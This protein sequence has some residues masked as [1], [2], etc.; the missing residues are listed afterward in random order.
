MKNSAHSFKRASIAAK[1]TPA[2]RAAPRGAG[3]YTSPLTSSIFS[4]GFC[5]ISILLIFSGLRL[6]PAAIRRRGVAYFATAQ[7]G[8]GAS[9]I[10]LPLNTA[11]RRL[12]AH[13]VARIRLLRSLCAHCV[14][15]IRLRRLASI[16][17]KLIARK[18][19]GFRCVVSQISFGHEIHERS[20]ESLELAK[21]L[22]QT[23]RYLD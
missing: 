14:A 12:C 7:Y 17:P 20:F 13:C 5:A 18:V 6:L 10:S 19:F 22:R 3:S 11:P 4:S 21:I 8:A 9:P 16:D 15:R 23:T 2:T 1:S